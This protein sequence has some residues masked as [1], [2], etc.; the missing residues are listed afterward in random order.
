M[1]GMRLLLALLIAGATFSLGDSETF[2]SSL[3]YLEAPVPSKQHKGDRI[4][5]LVVYAGSS[6]PAWFDMFLF[7]AQNSRDIVDWH[8]FVTENH[9]IDT[10]ENV[11]FH[12][13][14]FEELCK[15][16][17]TVDKR[18]YKD[19]AD[20]HAQWGKEMG[21]ALERFPYLLV[22]FKPCLGWLFSEYIEGYSHW[23]LADIDT[24]MGR[25]SSFVSAAEG[26]ILD[27]E[28]L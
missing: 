9:A 18:S 10:P 7:S 5:G 24:L 16:L 15:R 2:S 13:I 1:T 22:E 12:H 19:G 21:T 20:S 3:R 23:A 14:S 17:V 27:Y 26:K 11:F 4:A 6:L 25:F 8:V 28:Y